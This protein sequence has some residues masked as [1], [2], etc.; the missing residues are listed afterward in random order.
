MNPFELGVFGSIN[1]N[2]RAKPTQVVNGD[3]GKPQW[4]QPNINVGHGGSQNP[5][6]HTAGIDLTAIC[7]L[8]KVTLH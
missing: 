2:T 7:V 3:R 6:A 8:A 1:Q 4:W 5:R